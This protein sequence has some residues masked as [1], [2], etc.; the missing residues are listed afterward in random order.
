MEYFIVEYNAT[1]FNSSGT[2]TK[3]YVQGSNDVSVIIGGLFSGDLYNVKAYV[4]IES[5]ESE[6]ISTQCRP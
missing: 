6:E 3:P 5:L 2:I 1:T 4:I